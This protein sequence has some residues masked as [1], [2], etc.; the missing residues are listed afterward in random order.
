MSAHPTP[1]G[2][3]G[4]QGA[5]S[6]PGWPFSPLTPQQA[7]RHAAQAQALREGR[8]ARWPAGCTHLQDIA[9]KPAPWAAS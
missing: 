7:L 5:P 9:A 3:Q 8:L 1:R 2:Q 6:L 4:P